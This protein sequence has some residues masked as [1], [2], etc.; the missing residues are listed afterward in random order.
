MEDES[1]MVKIFTGSEIAAMH[2]KGI[3]EEIGLPVK[4]RNDYHVELTAGFGGV[5]GSAMVDLYILER[6]LDKAQPIID[7]FSHGKQ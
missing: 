5:A 1:S 6:N 7:E 3:L 2:L 4:I